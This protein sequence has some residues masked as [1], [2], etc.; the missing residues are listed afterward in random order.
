MSDDGAL[1]YFRERDHGIT[2]SLTSISLRHGLY[3]IQSR[4]RVTTDMI[5]ASTSP[6]SS[7]TVAIVDAD[8]STR[9]SLHSLLSTLGVSV[10]SFDCAED[11][12]TRTDFT[13]RCV[14]AA[15]DLPG[16]SGMELLQ[17]LHAVNS[18]L[19]VILLAGEADVPTAVAAMRE[20]ASDFIEK[21][22]V[23]FAVLRR[24]S[25]LLDLQRFNAS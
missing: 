19:A 16:M 18:M 5:S 1:G 22:H 21:P 11:F 12:L 8:A 6:T 3:A 7:P 15:L 9:E 4:G 2:R 20:G 17:H 14:I 25:Q 23:D 24:V 13:P 10:E